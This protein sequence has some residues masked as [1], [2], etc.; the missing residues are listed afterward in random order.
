[1]DSFE[2][3]L[4]SAAKGFLEAPQFSGGRSIRYKLFSTLCFRDDGRHWHQSLCLWDGIIPRSSREI[5]VLSL[6]M[7][8]QQEYGGS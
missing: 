1:M 7:H 6:C 5:W 3:L 8:Q 4:L 2:V